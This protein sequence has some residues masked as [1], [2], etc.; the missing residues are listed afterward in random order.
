V[1]GPAVKSMSGFGVLKWRLGPPHPTP[2]ARPAA[3]KAGRADVSSACAGGVFSCHTR[4]VQR[5]RRASPWW[6]SWPQDGF[7]TSCG[8]GS[9]V[10]AVWAAFGVVPAGPGGEPVHELLGT[11]RARALG[12]R[13]H[14]TLRADEVGH[15]PI[16][17]LGRRRAARQ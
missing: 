10:L 8:H 1:N 11:Q 6:R 12:G 14:G 3:E 5:Q 15:R 16:Q 9:I 7:S 2:A 17:L 13:R 4:D